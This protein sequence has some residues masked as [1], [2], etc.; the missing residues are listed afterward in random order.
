MFI[1]RVPFNYQT[2]SGKL[3]STKPGDEVPDF[4]EWPYVCQKAHLNLGWVED[5]P[6]KKV[7]ETRNEEKPKTNVNHK[8]KGHFRK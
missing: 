5:V 7:E 3:V 2:K 8:G 1:V 6:D 4:K